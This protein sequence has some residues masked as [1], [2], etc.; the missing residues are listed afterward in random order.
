MLPPASR[1]RRPRSKPALLRGLSVPEMNWPASRAQRPG[2]EPA[3]LHRLRR[4]SSKLFL[5]VVD[6]PLDYCLYAGGYVGKEIV[7]RNRLDLVHAH[8][9]RSPIAVNRS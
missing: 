6:L 5:L 9:V 8:P 1:A 7:T 2:N 3:L 4:T